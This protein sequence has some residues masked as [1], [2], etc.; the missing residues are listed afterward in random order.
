V[1]YHIIEVIQCP[2]RTLTVLSPIHVSGVAILGIPI[3]PTFV[4]VVIFAGPAGPVLLLRLTGTNF[5]RPPVDGSLQVG[6]S[7]VGSLPV[8]K[9]NKAVSRV[10]RAD[11][12]N[13]NVDVFQMIESVVPEKG[14]DIIRFGVVR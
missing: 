13:R 8:K 12:V 4:N 7:S 14:F 5:N 9:V 11:W 10:S 6:K 3:T 1:V 2:V